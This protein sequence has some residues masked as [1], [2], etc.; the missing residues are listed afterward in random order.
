[1]KAAIRMA[2][3][4]DAACKAM[5]AGRAPRRA[6]RIPRRPG[7]A[8]KS[9]PLHAGIGTDAMATSSWFQRFH[10]CSLQDP[11][12]HSCPK[13]GIWFTE[14]EHSCSPRGNLAYSVPRPKRSKLNVRDTGLRAPFHYFMEQE[15]ASAPDNLDE[16]L[17]Y[18]FRSPETESLFAA[19]EDRQDLCKALVGKVLAE[20][21]TAAGIKQVVFD[22]GGYKYHGQ[23]KALADA[24]RENGLEF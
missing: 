24:S 23:I 15:I 11:H 2:P 4:M 21:A 16:V 20:R 10:L 13:A 3:S 6:S 5:F 19:F 7:S 18:Y 9:D 12:A 22:R 17:R 1:M 14:R 8:V